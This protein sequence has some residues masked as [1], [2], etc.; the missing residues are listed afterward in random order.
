VNLRTAV[1][2]LSAMLITVFGALSLALSRTTALLDYESRELAK[3]GESI[4]LAQGLKLRLL[5]VN[6][7][8]LLYKLH[9]EP[10]RL[11]SKLSQ[12]GEVSDFLNQVSSLLTTQ[13]ETAILAAIRHDIATYLQKLDAIEISRASSLEKYYLASQDVDHAIAAVDR[14]VEINRTESSRQLNEISKKNNEA[15]RI[16]AALLFTGAFI[17]LTVVLT[18]FGAIIRPLTGIARTIKRYGKGDASARAQLSGV[19]EIREIGANFNSM[20]QSLEEKRQDQLRF[21]ASIAHDLRNPL[22]AISMASE[23]LREEVND[24]QNITHIIVRQVKVLDRLVGDLLDTARIEAGEL[25]LHTAEVDIGRLVRDAVALHKSGSELHRFTVDV[26][27]EPLPAKAD[28]ARISQVMNNLLSNAIK[29]SPNGG[30]IKVRAW[31]ESAAIRITV[32]DRGI[33]ISEEDLPDIFKPFNRSKATRGT[34]PGIGLGLSASR[35][36]IESHGGVLQVTSTAGKGSTFMIILR[37]LESDRKRD[38][39]TGAFT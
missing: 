7:N 15:G 32:T 12:R 5:A 1:I 17:I 9:G 39:E 19:N 25:D 6:R 20:A 35:R 37:A 3:S 29:Y 28:P 38:L 8:T 14:L 4:R 2:I 18:A 36:I 34:I 30:K 13:E 10:W 16:A 33:G 27:E 11:E 31:Q 21:I 26:P 24:E 22:S 23:I